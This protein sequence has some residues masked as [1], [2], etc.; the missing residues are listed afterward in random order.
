MRM[1]NTDP[2]RIAR[3]INGHIHNREEWF[4]KLAVQT[5]TDWG[6]AESYVLMP[7]RAFFDSE[8]DFLVGVHEYA[9]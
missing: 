4:G 9:I 2:E 7:Y 1:T 3:I 8:I 5:A 6:E